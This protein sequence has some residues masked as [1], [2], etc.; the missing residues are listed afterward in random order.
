MRYLILPPISPGKLFMG[1]SQNE[2]NN[3]GIMQGTTQGNHNT[4]L[5]IFVVGQGELASGTDALDYEA[6]L[7][8]GKVFQSEIADQI[9]AQLQWVAGEQDT[10]AA[11]DYAAPVAP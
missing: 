9:L 6:L 3:S 2:I 10:K 11:I 7:R 8:Q 4:V 1:A 5:N